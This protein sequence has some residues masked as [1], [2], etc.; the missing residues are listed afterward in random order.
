MTWITWIEILAVVFSL[1]CVLLIIRENIW[2]WLVGIIGVLGYLLVFLYSGLYG[3]MLLQ[4]V[5]I[6]LQIY[7]WRE[8]L[9]GGKDKGE[10]K[11]SRLPSQLIIVL[12]FGGAV[13]TAAMATLF[14]KYTNAAMPLADSAAT[15]LSLIAQ[16]MLAKKY[17]ENW[18]V[19]M[20]VNII[21]IFIGIYQQLFLTA[22]LYTVFFVLAILGFL[23]WQK[24]YRSLQKA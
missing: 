13:A 23:A 7:G 11:I 22:G 21:T 1:V 24:S 16:W 8:W 5:F 14:Q 15:A 6:G 2:Q 9:Y 17:L 12:F 18:L 10:L 4:V 3:L 19:W 20:V